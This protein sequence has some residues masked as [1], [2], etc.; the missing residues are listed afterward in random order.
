MLGL[1][2]GTGLY[3][4]IG[5]KGVSLTRIP[6]AFGLL[7][8]GRVGDGEGE[9]SPFNALMT[10]LSSTI[11]TGNIAGVATAVGIGGPGALFWMWCA[12][13]LGIAT[14]YAEAVLAVRF[15]ET[16]PTGKRVG[17]PM[18]Y[19]K[20]GLSA[21]WKF[22]GI[23]FAVFGA[24][25]GFGL[26]NTVQSNT[27]S[28]ALMSTYSIPTIV[29]GVIMSSL[30]ALV[31]LGGLKRIAEVAGRLVPLMAMLYLSCTT[32]ILLMNFSEIPGAFILIVDSAFN[33]V[34]AGGGFAGS[35]LILALRMGVA[36]G[37]FSN[38]AGLGSAPIA[39]A[40][41]ETNNPVKQGSIAMLG[42]FIDTLIVCTMTGLVL[43]VSGV[44]KGEAAGAAMTLMAFNANLPFGESLLTICIVLFAFTSMLG[45]SYYG[46]RCAE[47]LMGPKIVVPFRVLW[48]I[49][50]FLGTQLSLGMVWK[51]SDLLNGLM[52]FPNLI[53]LILLSPVV[54]KLTREYGKEEFTTAVKESE[55]S[56]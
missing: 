38:E 40:A 51:I 26:A 55:K 29:S 27:V 24:F 32:L 22:L 31:L 21:K 45:W 53:A 4:T 41:A 16:D 3:L 52:A 2:L 20:N 43:V 44:W 18:Y 28:Q 49:G 5:L 33:G 47:F 39:H 19:I 54:F 46:E 9:I 7:I 10:A 48:V 42:T 6:H 8:R 56:V 17:G 12:A 35:T 37:I 50:V 23:L 1:I 36:R 30:V 25:A 13:V 11:G 34:A 14:K 15:R